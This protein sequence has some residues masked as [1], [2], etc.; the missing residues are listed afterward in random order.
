M[1]V[2]MGKKEMNEETAVPCV[3]HIP[4]DQQGQHT[5]QISQIALA[6]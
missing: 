2:I 1:T 3:V 6:H 5:R 4:N